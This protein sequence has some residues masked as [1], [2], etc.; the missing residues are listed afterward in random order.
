MTWCYKLY[1][2]CRSFR[3][4]AVKYQRYIMASHGTL[5]LALYYMVTQNM[6]RTYKGK[7][8]FFIN[9]ICDCSRSN[10]MPWT[11]KK[12]DIA[13]YVRIRIGLFE[14]EQVQEPDPTMPFY[15]LN[16][17]LWIFYK[18]KAVTNILHIR[19]WLP[20][21]ITCNQYKFFFNFYL[22]AV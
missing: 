20:Y 13:T 22:L 11:D 12:S 21:K 1:K 8:F 4:R 15:S 6:V 14:T 16:I 18:Q 10:Q 3:F 17:Y 19:I 9:T 5:L 7:F 2:N